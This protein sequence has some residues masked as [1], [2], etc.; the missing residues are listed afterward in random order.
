MFLFYFAKCILRVLAEICED[1]KQCK[2]TRNLLTKQNQIK[3][4]WWI[5]RANSNFAFFQT[6]PYSFSTQ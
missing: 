5:A 1:S 6:P 2:V 3:A 4:T